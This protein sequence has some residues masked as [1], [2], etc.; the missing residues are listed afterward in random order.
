[1]PFLDPCDTIVAQLTYEGRNLLAR[2]KF[3]D[4]AFRVAGWQ[5][6]RGGYDVTDPVKVT[7]FID[8]AAVAV[9]YVKI[10]SN[11]FVPG[12]KVVLNG[13]TFDYGVVWRGGSTIAATISNIVDA[14]LANTDTRQYRIVVPEADLTK[15][16]IIIVSL[17]PGNILNAYPIWTESTQPVSPFAVTALSG[18]VSTTLENPAYPVPPTLGEFVS[19]D[20]M[21]ENVPIP[22]SS[23]KINST[24]ITTGNGT[25]AYSGQILASNL[26]VQVWPETGA[27][28]PPELLSLA[29]PDPNNNDL[30]PGPGTIF[31]VVN[32]TTTGFQ[33]ALTPGG[34]PIIFQTTAGTG[35][36]DVNIVSTTAYSFVSRIGS[37]PVGMNAYGEIG[38][39]VELLQSTLY[40]EVFVPF[41]FG[42]ANVDVTH[43]RI[44]YIGHNLTQNLA[45]TV[46]IASGLTGTLPGGILPGVTYYVVNPIY[47]SFQLSLLPDG[48]PIVITSPGTGSQNMLLN[49]RDGG[50]VGRRVLFAHSHFPIQAKTDRSV[51]TFRTIVTY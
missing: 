4:V 37:G 9:W 50:P 17:I 31:Y 48:V 46:S 21:I 8:P 49:S 35:T 25:I 41:I 12:D 10:L 6:G 1:M 30:P 42:P 43:D 51:L 24:D 29:L 45:V 32:P 38:I 22:Y 40:G 39:W 20:G 47:G 19:P 2:A 3:G 5:M 18:G 34:T 13:V 15:N 36:F 26:Q 7:P 27:T 23:F 33:L 16:R 44:N 28:L 14:I 11:S